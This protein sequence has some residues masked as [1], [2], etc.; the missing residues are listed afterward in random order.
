MR[1]MT[2]ATTLHARRR[3][4]RSPAD[5]LPDLYAQRTPRAKRLSPNSAR[6]WLSGYPALVAQWHPKKN[7]D[8]FPDLVRYGSAREVWWTCPRGPDH[9]WRASVSNRV[10]G[11]RC[12]F[13]T[14]RYPSVTNSLASLRPDVAAEWHPTRNKALRPKDVVAGSARR[15]WWKCPK[16]SDHEWQ[17]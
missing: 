2:L 12:P 14:N 15:V 1:G 3:A 8:L 5:Q 6:Y 17:T 13:C 7:G 4:R 11:A 16:S 10:R 9:E